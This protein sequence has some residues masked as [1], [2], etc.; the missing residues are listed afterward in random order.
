VRIARAQ[1]DFAEIY[2]LERFPGPAITARVGLLLSL[3]VSAES[4]LAKTASRIPTIV[5]NTDIGFQHQN[6]KRPLKKRRQDGGVLRP[7]HIIAK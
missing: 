7:A 1:S 2:S 3:T 6:S 5:N 4:A